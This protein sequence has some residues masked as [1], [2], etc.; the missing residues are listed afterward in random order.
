MKS[1]LYVEVLR[2]SA[3]GGRGF[4]WQ[5]YYRGGPWKFQCVVRQSAD[6][7]D[8]YNSGSEASRAGKRAL[9]TLLRELAERQGA[10]GGAGFLGKSVRR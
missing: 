2:P 6:T 9:R 10:P 5:I 8:F 7:G 1:G 3:T 4:G